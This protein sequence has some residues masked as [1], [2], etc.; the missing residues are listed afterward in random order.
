VFAAHAYPI[1]DGLSTFIVETDE[2]TWRRSGLD[3]F[4]VTAPPGPSDE[5]TQRYLERLFGDQIEGHPLV[6]NNSRWANFRTRRARAWRDGA[7]VL[8]GDAAH[9]AHFSVGSGTKMAMEDA[10]ALTDALERNSALPAALE[11]YEAERRPRVEHIQ[12]AAAASFDWWEGFRHVYA[13]PAPRFT[14]HLLTRAQLRYDTL[15][16]RDPAFLAAV[17]AEAGLGDLRARMAGTAQPGPPADRR[18]RL[19]A[20]AGGGVAWAFSE[21]IAA[22][23]GLDPSW[24]EA[25]AGLQVVARLVGGDRE[26]LVAAARAAEAAGFHG[27]ELFFAHATAM[28]RLISP[29]TNPV[30]LEQRLQVPLEALAAVRAAWP[31]DR[32]LLVAFAADDFAP[33]GISPADALETAR[34]FHAAGA[35]MIDV[36]GG[37]VTPLSRPPYGRAFRMLIAGRVRNEAHVPVITAGGITDLD[38][39]RTVLLS[40]RADMVAL[41]AV[42]LCE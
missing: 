15:K 22:D 9:T 33:G 7:L 38:D 18:S 42:R 10:L 12:R 14:F 35:T 36:L 27:L 16:D 26:S 11:A 21:P 29:L 17:E 28:A 32:P 4:D 25:I 1:G 41:D 39:V 30:P 8:L 5:A 24:R 20:A 23:S 13:F 34:R 31:A 6:A 40:G 3:A 37:H 2:E 19:E